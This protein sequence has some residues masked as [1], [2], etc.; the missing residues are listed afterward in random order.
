MTPERHDA[1]TMFIDSPESGPEQTAPAIADR[2]PYRLGCVGYLNTLPLIEGLGKL[3]DLRLTLTPPARLADLLASG[4]I[5]MG[6]LSAIDFQRLNLGNHAGA[7]LCMVPA[8]MIGCD[9]PTLTVRLFS[10]VPFEKVTR[11]HADIDSHTSVALARIILAER[12]GV[13][14]ETIDFDADAERVARRSSTTHAR[15]QTMLLI[16]DK[17]VTDAPPADLY[18]HQLDLGEAWKELTGLPFVYAV[19]MCRDDAASQDRARAVWAILDRQRRHNATRSRWIVHQRAE[20]RGWPVDLAT[21]YT[22]EL[23]R[24]EVKDEHKRAVEAF[25]DRAHK[26]ALIDSRRSSR[27]MEIA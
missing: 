9:G 24:Y 10:A 11:L 17:V 1:A 14:P 6:L 16:G 23:L 20:S 8:G 4:D 26:H 21:R 18:P 27:W 12:F 25:F 2:P 5:E 13:K 15:P 19:W 22:S 3:R 7:G